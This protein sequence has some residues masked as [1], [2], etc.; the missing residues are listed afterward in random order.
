LRPGAERASAQSSGTFSE[1]PAKDVAG[2]IAHLRGSGGKVNVASNGNGTASRLTAELFASV[3]GARLNHIPTR[4][5]RPVLN[6]L[7]AGHLDASFIQYSAFY[8]LH[9]AG[10]ARILSL[11]TVHAGER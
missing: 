3:V 7:M 2:F 10:R 4:E 9:Q 6:D 8:D 11:P 5:R 1:R